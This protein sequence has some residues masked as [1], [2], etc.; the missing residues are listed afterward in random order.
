MW[1]ARF[2]SFVCFSHHFPL[3]FE[4]SFMISDLTH[5]RSCIFRQFQSNL[6]FEN[7][8]SFLNISWRENGRACW[9][10]LFFF[11][12]SDL[13]TRFE[14]D[15]THVLPFPPFH[16][17]LI[18]RDSR[19]II[20][21]NLIHEFEISENL[22]NTS[23]CVKSSDLVIL[24]WRWICLIWS[25]KID[26][27]LLRAT[28]FL[29]IACFANLNLNLNYWRG[30]RWNFMKI[31]LTTFSRL[32]AISGSQWW[33]INLW[34]FVNETISLQFSNGDNSCSLLT[35]ATFLINISLTQISKKYRN[36]FWSLNKNSE[37]YKTKYFQLYKWCENNANISG[38]LIIL[39]FLRPLQ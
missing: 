31:S 2:R 35:K 5:G 1:R 24:D 29:S 20:S 39:Q 17:F 25:E 12:T 16:F 22:L 19:G 3:Q 32:N 26:F 6:R 14:S 4:W 38:R 28:F 10:F 11:S 30:E 23:E 9:I 27:S 37:T 7:Q 13:E 33:L 8:I 36:N 21:R 18:Y 34:A 15:I